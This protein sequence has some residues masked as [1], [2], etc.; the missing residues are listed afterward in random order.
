VELFSKSKLNRGLQGASAAPSESNTYIQTCSD[1]SGFLEFRS[2]SSKMEHQ[3][4]NHMTE[5]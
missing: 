5:K 2:K 4:N 1:L 3:F